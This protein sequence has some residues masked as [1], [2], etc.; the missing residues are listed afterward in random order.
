MKEVDSLDQ[1][2]EKLLDIYPECDADFIG[3]VA[4]IAYIKANHGWHDAKLI[5]RNFLKH[6][7]C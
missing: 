7:G 1:F 4:T 5:Y 6:G 3:V 2:M